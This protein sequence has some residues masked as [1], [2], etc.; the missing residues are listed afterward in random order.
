MGQ[1]RF[2]SPHMYNDYYL[3][4]VGNGTPVYSGGSLQQGYGI[5]GLL[6]IGFRTVLP[7]LKPLLK[8]G[9]QTLIKRTFKSGAKGAMESAIGSGVDYAADA[10]QRRLTRKPNKRKATRRRSNKRNK[11]SRRMATTIKQHKRKPRTI[12]VGSRSKTRIPLRAP[13]I[14]DE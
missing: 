1:R 14:F 12:K 9:G 8:R 5:G 10:L 4:Q 13:D 3:H 11:T 7:F 6:A 2:V